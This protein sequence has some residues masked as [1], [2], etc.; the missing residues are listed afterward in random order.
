MTTYRPGLLL[1]MFLIGTISCPGVCAA[2]PGL[3]RVEYSEIVMGVKA[4]IVLYAPDEGSGRRAARAGVSRG[5]GR[6]G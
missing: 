6:R 5:S 4:R 2:S 3:Q 1:L